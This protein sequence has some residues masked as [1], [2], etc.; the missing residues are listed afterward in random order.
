[1]L[2]EEVEEVV[3]HLSSMEVDKSSDGAS[4]LSLKVRHNNVQIG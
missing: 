1:M 3:G 4:F 2:V